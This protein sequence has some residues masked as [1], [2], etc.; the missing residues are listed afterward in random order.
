MHVLFVHQNYPAQF[1][2]IAHRLVTDLG[3]KCT[4]V[5]RLP[6][7]RDGGIRLVQYQLEGSATADNHPCAQ[8]FENQI[9]HAHAVYQAC[10]RR[11]SSAPDLI[12]GHSG[13][14]STIFL[15]ELFDCPIVNYFEYYYH[16]RNSDIDFRPEFQP[17]TMD[18]LRVRARNA[19]ILL[20]LDN[21]DAGYCPTYWQRS[22]FPAQFQ[23]KLEVIFDGIDT[24]FWRRR[25][26]KTRK[27]C[28]REVSPK[29]RIVTYV[30][31]GLEAMRGFDI[32]MQVARRIYKAY[33]N[34]LFVVVGADRTFYGGDE[35]YI[36]HATF[37]EHVLRNNDYDLTRFCFTGQ[38]PA[39]QL[40]K[41]LS[42]TDLHIYLSVPF[43]L[44]WSVFNALSCECVVL[45]SDV[46]PVTEIV[47]HGTNGLLADFYDIDE[48]VRQSLDVL[49][50]PGAY[51]G[52]GKA[53]ATLIREK[54]GLDRCLSNITGFFQ[55]VRRDISATAREQ[56]A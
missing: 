24:R 50:D 32:F 18:Y 53:G 38:V 8:T 42:L 7:R 5:S 21:C 31:S 52:L 48:L 10:E 51:R 55:S 37:K 26:M 39:N 17:S 14:G 47:Q 28:G 54:Y 46:P 16:A 43:V 12:V 41:L 9:W 15:R 20:D 56:M 3:W 11:L 49:R 30:A 25:R 13:F 33:P 2:H 1:G 19:M 29:T 27:V 44:S 22:L 23:P 40:V 34:V 45:A 35:R 6:A 4:F 36:K